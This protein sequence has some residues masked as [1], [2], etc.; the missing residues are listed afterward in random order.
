MPVVYRMLTNNLGNV[1]WGGYGKK[2]ARPGGIALKIKIN[3]FRIKQSRSSSLTMALLMKSL[4]VIP[5]LA[6]NAATRA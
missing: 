3:H 1:F 5:V 2:S 4:M 6:A